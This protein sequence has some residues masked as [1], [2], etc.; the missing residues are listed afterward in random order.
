MANRKTNKPLDV[1]KLSFEQAQEQLQQIVT[2][3]EQGKIGLEESIRQYELG[4]KLI[5]HCRK[6]L[7]QAEH[8]V[9]TL[10]KTVEG[11]LEAADMQPPPEPNQGSAD[12]ADSS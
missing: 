12:Q 6:I 2:D 10:S 8:K 5:Q 3:I 4:C 9:Q 7:D 1:E 11:K